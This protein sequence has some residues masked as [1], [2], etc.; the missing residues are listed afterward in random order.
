[1]RGSGW[2]ATPTPARPP[3]GTS[4]CSVRRPL[5]ERGLSTCDARKQLFQGSVGLRAN[6]R[7]EPARERR[8][9][10]GSPGGRGRSTRLLPLTAHEGCGGLESVPGREL[11]FDHVQMWR[12]VTDPQV[13]ERRE[14]N[15]TWVGV[16]QRPDPLSLR[17]NI[18]LSA[19]TVGLGATAPVARLPSVH[20]PEWHDQRGSLVLAQHSRGRDWNTTDAQT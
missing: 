13:W 9:S 19:L 1:V 2:A 12:Q 8:S 16:P 11:V 14:R 5:L 6:S 15:R 4:S 3:L 18:E 17:R 7:G 10:S 20:A